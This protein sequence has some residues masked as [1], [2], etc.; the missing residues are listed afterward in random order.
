MMMFRYKCLAIALGSIVFG[1]TN[2]A[3]ACDL[4]AIYSSVESQRPV[5]GTF[6]FTVAEQYTDQS[7]VQLDGAKTDNPFDQYLK[8]SVTQLVVGYDPLEKLQLQ[9]AVP[10]IA[11]HYRRAEEEE[12]TR[13]S[14]EGIGDISLLARY[15]AYYYMQDDSVINLQL[16]AG[17]KLPTG[18]SS[19]LKEE[20]EE[21]HHHSDR[22]HAP[23]TGEEEIESVVHG[24]D[25]ALGSG[26]VDFPLGISL[27][28][29]RGR[30]F[31]TANAQYTLRTKGDHTY[32]YADDFNWD[33]GPAYYLLLQDEYRLALRAAFSGGEKGRDSAQNGIQNDTQVNSS[34]A[35][36]QLIFAAGRYS[37]ELSGDF[38]LDVDN[39]GLQTVP[40]YRIRAACSVR[41]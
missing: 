18:D 34:F 29:Q 5:A 16:G 37:A 40:T 1:F 14:E 30:F 11:R 2:L 13:G 36:P 10:Y 8:S 33:L 28:A 17:I 39:S 38:P 3:L 15:L 19:R 25:L 21:G 20:L 9:L 22:M 35:G 24:H 32:E 12:I 4:C 26:S 7:K 23:E 31:F 27:L 41:F 6:R